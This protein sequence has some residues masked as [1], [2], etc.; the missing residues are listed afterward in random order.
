MSRALPQPPCMRNAAVVA[1]GSSSY[2]LAP[3]A[4]QVI[5][6]FR[7]F[8]AIPFLEPGRRAKYSFPIVFAQQHRLVL[9][10]AR[11]ELHAGIVTDRCEISDGLEVRQTN[12]TVGRI[13][14]A[15]PPVL[16][17]LPAGHHLRDS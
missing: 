11:A 5:N 16:Q 17:P 2:E 10:S 8:L 6:Q 9:K 14:A 1:L 4:E 13:Q 15:D 3:P 7:S 12:L